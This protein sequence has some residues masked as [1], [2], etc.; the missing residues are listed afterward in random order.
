MWALGFS[1]LRF[2]QPAPDDEL[3]H[4]ENEQSQAK[5]LTMLSLGIFKIRTCLLVNTNCWGD[6]GSSSTRMLHSLS[7]RSQTLLWPGRLFW[8]GP[9]TLLTPHLLH[10]PL[11]HLPLYIL[12]SYPCSV[13]SS[14][15]GV[16]LFSTQA[17]SH[18]AL[19]F[20]PHPSKSPPVFP[21]PLLHLGVCLIEPPQR[22]RLCH[23]TWTTTKQIRF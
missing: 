11:P 22:R 5:R 18:I 23:M 13:Y 20:A 15:T 12:Y 2:M 6:C 9:C 21:W 10:P 4:P 1:P 3:L 14:H 7:V 8:S 19:A 17:H 16:I